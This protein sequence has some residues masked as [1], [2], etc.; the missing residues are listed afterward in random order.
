VDLQAVQADHLV[1]LA[2]VVCQIPAD[3]A[4][5]VVQADYQVQRVLQ[6]LQE[7]LVKMVPV[8]FLQQ[9]EHRVHPAVLVVAVQMVHLAQVEV[10]HLQ[11]VRVVPQVAV[12]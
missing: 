6:V 8:V 11:V 2:Q 4:D 1:R 5:L 10:V 3:Q 9:M 7:V 12:V